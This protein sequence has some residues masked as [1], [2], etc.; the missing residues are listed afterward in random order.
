[1]HVGCAELSSLLRQL[2]AVVDR[3][4]ALYPGRKFTVDGHLL[5]SIGEVVAEYSY[6]LVLSPLSTEGHDAIAP[7]GRLVQVKLTQGDSRVALNG[8]CDFLIAMRLVDRKRFVEVYNGPGAPVWAK[9]GKV[10][11]NGQAP[12]GL[13]KLRELNASVADADRIPQVNPFPF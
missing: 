11:K 4:E 5:G 3:L 7:D 9:A 13:A 2:Y 6:G 10:Q 12:I 1:M 8:P